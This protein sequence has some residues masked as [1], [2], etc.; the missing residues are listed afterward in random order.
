V[1][2]A[3]LSGLAVGA[4]YALMSMGFALNLE[5]ADIVNAAHGAF[6]VGAMYLT[7]VLAHAGVTFWIAIPIATVAAGVVSWAVYVLLVRPARAQEGHRIQLVFTLLLLSGL[8]V[9]YEI[10]FGPDFRAYGERF[11]TVPIAGGY[12]TVPQLVAIALAVVIAVG[13][14]L[15]AKRTMVGKLA[16]VASRYPLGARSIGVP[17]DRIYTAVFVLA[18]LLAG[19]AGGIIVLFQ[20]VDPTQSL[21]YI[22][23]VFLVAL[24]ARTNLIGCLILGFVY[25]V[26]QSVTSYY[27]EATAATTITLLLFIVALVGGYVVRTAAQWVR[28]MGPVAVSGGVS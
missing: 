8:T 5:I 17:V 4:I 19:L 14:Y 10:L 21:S 18:G 24:V 26:V 1:T 22:L 28:R 6:V 12:L 3:L 7:L 9:A 25:G 27:L 11:P 23:I 20:P 13:L 2:Q 16:Y 15:V